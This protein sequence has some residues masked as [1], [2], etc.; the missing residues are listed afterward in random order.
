MI[1]ISG[2][3]ES[4]DQYIRM[5]VI[6]ASGY[7]GVENQV[8]RVSEHQVIRVQEIRASGYQGNLNERRNR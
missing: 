6:R 1:R 3:R 7:Q 2:C 8:T 5:L 4:G